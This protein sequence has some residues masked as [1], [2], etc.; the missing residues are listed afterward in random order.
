MG[1]QWAIPQVLAAFD[2]VTSRDLQGLAEET[3]CD[4]YLNLQLLGRVGTEEFPL[5]D[6]T[7]G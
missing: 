7:L 4:D 1:E 5:I 3:I 2:R 6:F